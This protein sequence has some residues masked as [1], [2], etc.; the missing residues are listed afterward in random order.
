MHTQVHTHHNNDNAPAQHEMWPQIEKKLHSTYWTYNETLVWCCGFTPKTK[1]G[2]KNVMELHKNIWK[3]CYMIPNW[4]HNFEMHPNNKF[5]NKLTCS[6]IIIGYYLLS[7]TYYVN[8][9]YGQ[10]LNTFS[11]LQ[12]MRSYSRS[13]EVNE[14]QPLQYLVCQQGHAKLWWWS[15]HS[16]CSRVTGG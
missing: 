11:Y 9:C 1:A 8:I 3:N 7:V 2:N 10:C 15:E 4:D 14:E 16:S 6:V 5:R 13:S 12:V